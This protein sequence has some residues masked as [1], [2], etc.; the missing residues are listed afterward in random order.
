MSL[1]EQLLKSGLATKEQAKKANREAK[2]RAH[3]ATVA[4]RKGNLNQ[5]DQEAATISEAE[6]KMQALRDADMLR[7]QQLNDERLQ[8]EALARAM[9]IM[10]TH[11]LCDPKGELSYSFLVDSKRIATIRINELQI[12]QLASGQIAIAAW[13]SDFRF[14]LVSEANADKIRSCRSDLI[15]CQHKGAVLAPALSDGN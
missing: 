10:I 7:N 14:L 2:V 1:R 13:D 8:K 11:D 5:A 6:L 9:D 3:Q 15:V 12:P 4:E